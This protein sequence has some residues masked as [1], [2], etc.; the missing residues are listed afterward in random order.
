MP[1]PDELMVWCENG[2]DRLRPF[3]L[4]RFGSVRQAMGPEEVPESGSGAT[5]LQTQDLDAGAPGG[6]EGGY[7]REALYEVGLL[8]AG[9]DGESDQGAA[10][11]SC[12][13]CKLLTA[14][15]L[16]AGSW[17][18]NQLR[19][20]FSRAFAYVMLQTVATKWH[21]RRA[22]IAG[23]CRGTGPDVTSR[24]VWL[25]FSES[26]PYLSGLLRTGLPNCKPSRLC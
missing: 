12:L 6:G 16:I 1:S 23:E 9:R 21:S 10:V 11:G 25:S 22:G 24:K 18:A 5:L 7:G 8:R 15:R 17:Q 2:G 20:Y 19:L 26:Y 13:L 14:R 4:K 3:R